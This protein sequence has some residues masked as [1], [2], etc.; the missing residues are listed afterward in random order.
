LILDTI[1]YFMPTT[2]KPKA[3]IRHHLAFRFGKPILPFCA[4]ALAPQDGGGRCH[5]QLLE[6]AFREG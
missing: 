2:A 3:D 1:K 4:A 5:A 6:Y